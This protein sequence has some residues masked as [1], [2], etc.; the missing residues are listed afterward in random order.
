M[1]YI[2]GT[3][4]TWRSQILNIVVI[5]HPHVKLYHLKHQTHKHVETI[6]VSDK[7]TYDI[8]L[9]SSLLGDYRF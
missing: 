2:I 3:L 9:E 4:L 1:W 7:L 5:C 8:S 6:K